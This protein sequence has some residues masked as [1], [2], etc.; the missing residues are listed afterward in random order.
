[1]LSYSQQTIKLMKILLQ[2]FVFIQEKIYSDD[3][4]P[5]DNNTLTL[6]ISTYCKLFL[7][8]TA[9]FD[10]LEK[11][12]DPLKELIKWV[13]EVILPIVTSKYEFNQ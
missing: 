10:E 7:H 2:Y 5:I 3:L 6:A 8:I 11:D 4:I 13:E 12:V 1:M 9:S